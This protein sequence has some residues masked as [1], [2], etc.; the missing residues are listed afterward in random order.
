MKT[1]AIISLIWLLNLLQCSGQSF[2][3]LPII[4]MHVHV[5]STKSYKGG[6]ELKLKDTILSSPKNNVD[7]IRVVLE[8]MKKYN[9]VISYASGDFESLDS[10]N[11]QYPGKFFPSCEIGASQITNNNF[12]NRLNTKIKN[13]EV[14]GI[15]EVICALA[16]IPPNDPVMDTLYKIAEVN[17]LP[18]GI[19]LGLYPSL[20][21]PNVRL[22]Q[23]NPLLLQDVLRKFP[24]IRMN[25]MHAGMTLYPDELLAMFMYFPNLYADISSLTWYN[26]LVK[27]SLK[28]FLI[29]TMRC[30]FGDRIMFGSDEM[31]WPSSIG[32]AIDYIN[33]AV[34]LTEKQKRDILYNNAARYLKLSEDQIRKHHQTNK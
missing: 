3:G 22:E 21:N 25:V 34:F 4:D 11:K 16:G 33:N 19:H 6:T 7:H 2:S 26:D 30:G 1:L 10:L 18:I 17:Y 9:I 27:E 31:T 5:Y 14:Q 23:S 28:D 8:Q 29:K 20:R 15:G 13:G 32:L 12:I 24:K